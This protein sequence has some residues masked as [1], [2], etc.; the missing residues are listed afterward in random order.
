MVRFIAHRK[1]RRD[2]QSAAYAIGLANALRCVSVAGDVSD[3]K[4]VLTFSQPILSLATWSAGMLSFT[5]NGVAKVDASWVLT[6]PTVVTV[7]MTDAPV[8]GVT[9][10]TFGSAF[11]DVIFANGGSLVG[12]SAGGGT[13]A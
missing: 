4:I 13:V 10:V 12:T 9:I 5:C 6:S 3:N 11:E 2:R 8:A 1:N 7:T